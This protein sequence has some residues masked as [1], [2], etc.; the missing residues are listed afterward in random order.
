MIHQKE[1]FKQLKREERFRTITGKNIKY[2][3][4]KGQKQNII[5]TK[6]FRETINVCPWKLGST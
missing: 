2:I 1:N 5:T 6:K 3:E 4:R